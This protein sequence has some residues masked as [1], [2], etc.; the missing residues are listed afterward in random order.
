MQAS[1]KGYETIDAVKARGLHSL[2]VKQLAKEDAVILD[3]PEPAT[4]FTR[5][6]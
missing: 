5:V 3:I 1:I 2:M 6:L 4:S